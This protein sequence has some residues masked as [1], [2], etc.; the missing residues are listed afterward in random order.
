MSAVVH[1]LV[2]L[3]VSPAAA[4]VLY[5]LQWILLIGWIPFTLYGLFFSPIAPL[6][7]AVHPARHGV[8]M[9]PCH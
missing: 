2:A 4:K 9:V 5:I 1:K 6:H 8:T 3:R 7:D